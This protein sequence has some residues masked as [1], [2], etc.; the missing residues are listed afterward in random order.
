MRAGSMANA[1]KR[2]RLIAL[3]CLAGITLLAWLYMIHLDSSMM[4]MAGKNM[5]EISMPV[6][7]TGGIGDI[8]L[9]FLMWVVMMAGMMTPSAAPMILTFVGIKHQRRPGRTSIPDTLIFLLG[10]LLA[11][12]LFSTIATMIQQGLHSAAMVSLEITSISPVFSAILLVAAGFYQ[13]SPLKKICLSHCRTPLGFLMA[14]WRD[15]PGGELRLGF[16]HGFYCVGC[17]W[18]LMSILFVVGTMN[19]LWSALIA[20]FVILEKAVPGGIW[21]SRAFGLLLAGWGA[22]LLVRIIGM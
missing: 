9:T 8:L 1:L 6:M 7:Q 15:G 16:R 14:E 17:C 20:G 21:I 13:F 12:G 22:W 2:D 11:W 10:Y 5:N 4:G 19:L 3:V 18:L